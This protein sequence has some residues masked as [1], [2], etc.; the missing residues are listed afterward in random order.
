MRIQ[1]E[2]VGGLELLGEPQTDGAS[3]EVRHIS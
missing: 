2:E 1:S 3:D